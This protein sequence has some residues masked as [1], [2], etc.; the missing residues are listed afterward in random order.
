VSAGFHSEAQDLGRRSDR[1]LR[2][3]QREECSEGEYESPDFLCVQE[4]V[5]LR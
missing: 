2:T 3:E 4:A 5:V 1:T